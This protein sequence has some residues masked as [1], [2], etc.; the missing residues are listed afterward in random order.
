MIGV[1]LAAGLGS[2]LIPITYT[3]P[4][5]LTKI[6]G[7]TILDWQIDAY[8]EAGIDELIII[9]GY[10][11]EE[12]IQHIR[13]HSNIKNYKIINNTDFESTN[14]MYSLYLA[15]P[16]IDGKAFILSNADVVIDPGIVQA[17]AD[18]PK[19]NLIAADSSSYFEESMKVVVDNKGHCIDI[20]KKIPQEIAFGNSIDFYKFSTSLST[21]LF[22]LITTYIKKEKRLKDWTEV[23][24]QQLLQKYPDKVNVLDIAKKPWV[25]VDDFNDLALADKRFNPYLPNL[26]QKKIYFI[27]LDGTIYLGNKLIDGAVEFFDTLKRKKIPFYLVTNNSSTTPKKYKQKLSKFGIHVREDQILNPIASIVNFLKRHKIHDIYLLANKEVQEEIAK[28]AKVNAN[29]HKPEYVVVCYDT[30]LTFEKLRVAALHLNKGAGLLA[31][32][33]DI[34]CPTP[35]GPIPDVGAFLKLINATTQAEPIC[36]F[37]KPNAQMV[38]TTLKQHKISGKDAVVIG[39]RLYTDMQLAKNIGALSVLVLSGETSRAQLEET[40]QVPDVVVNNLYNLCEY[41]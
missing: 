2:R 13:F 5:C 3:K 40:S 1:I 34:V 35:D 38:E 32:H 36:Y 26:S 31:S 30:H 7:K 18:S 6:N 33:I 25:E 15:K 11:S 28:N 23:A 41:L 20:S 17:L 21:Q 29:S 16:F 4:K 12:I 14:N 22:K 10:K 9:V 27:D 39:D 19:Q 37:G 24:I 8:L